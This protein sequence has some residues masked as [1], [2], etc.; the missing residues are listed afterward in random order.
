MFA[1]RVSW[2]MSVVD[3]GAGL[4]P[5]V[6]GLFAV[7][8]FCFFCFFFLD[9]YLGKRDGKHMVQVCFL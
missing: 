2:Q 1:K 4:W 9:M 8:C 6:M 3:P 7:D 5:V